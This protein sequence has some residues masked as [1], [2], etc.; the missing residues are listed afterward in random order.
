MSHHLVP[1]E[2]NCKSSGL[3]YFVGSEE[4]KYFIQHFLKGNP[5]PQHLR[6][7]YLQTKNISVIVSEGLI[8]SSPPGIMGA[9]PRSLIL[10]V[11]VKDQRSLCVVNDQPV[12]NPKRKV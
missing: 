1:F 4:R 5:G 7:N 2:Y 12:G 11:D 8:G 6:P 3:V 9:N 10:Q